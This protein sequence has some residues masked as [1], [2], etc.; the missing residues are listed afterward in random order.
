[1]RISVVLSSGGSVL[2]TVLDNPLMPQKIHSIITDR[3]C[4]AQ[5]IA[6][7][8]R[9][10]LHEIF[11][12]DNLVF[13][14]ALLKYCNEE[15]IDFIIS[16][17]IRLYTGDILQVYKHKI[18]NF[19]LSLLPAFPGLKAFENAIEHGVKVLGTTVHFI[20][21]SID[22]GI[23][24]MQTLTPNDNNITVPE[25]RHLLFVQQ[26]KSLIQ[27]LDWLMAKRIL[28]SE[29]ACVVQDALFNNNEYLP[30][31]DSPVALNFT[32]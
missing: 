19:H 16:F 5:K 4:N 9:I 2:S 11:S 10:K 30:A 6:R 3:E 20:D 21:N 13:S 7:E 17:H 12:Q 18:I 28:V 25:R 31:L 27:L 14:D 32:I 23:P 1:V 24:I 15:K 29:N 8:H 22:M 26:C